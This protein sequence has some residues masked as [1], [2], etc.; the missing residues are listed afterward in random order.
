M[1]DMGGGSDGVGE[2]GQVG[3]AAD[4]L[5]FAFFFKP[6]GQADDI[7]RF[8]AGIKLLIVSNISLWL[9]L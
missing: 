4:S 1:D 2:L 3:A 5:Q 6:V 8:V 9:S 7:D